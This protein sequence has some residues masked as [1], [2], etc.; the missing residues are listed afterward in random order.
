MHSD[1]YVAECVLL[2]GLP[3]LWQSVWFGLQTLEP[4]SVQNAQN[5]FEPFE[6]FQL[7]REP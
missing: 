7:G 6:P 4:F 5:F 2:A 1:L 3:S